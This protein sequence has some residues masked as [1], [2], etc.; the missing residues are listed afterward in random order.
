[1]NE[2]TQFLDYVGAYVKD[3]PE[4]AAHVATAA[5]AGL[6]A[7]IMA[8]RQR[9]ADMEMAL[10]LAIDGAKNPVRASM[11]RDTLYRWHGKTSLRWDDYL[12]QASEK[13]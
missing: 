11:I 8:A 10:A 6:T 13:A 7:A 1:M 12:K 3:H 4:V 2:H 9:A 5:Q